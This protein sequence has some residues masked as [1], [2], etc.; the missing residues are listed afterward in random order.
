MTALLTVPE[1]AKALRLGTTKTRE[2]I[3]ARR[4]QAVRVDRSVRV[5]EEAIAEFLRAHL[6][7][8]G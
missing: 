6:D 2:L 3:A 7:L 5:P 4:L 1:A 8:G